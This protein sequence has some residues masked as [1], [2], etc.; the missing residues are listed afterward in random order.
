MRQVDTSL[1]EGQLFDR[2]F[3]ARAEHGE[4]RLL[5]DMRRALLRAKY[6]VIGTMLLGGAVAFA[7]AQTLEKRFTSYA[8]VMIDTRM[9]SEFGAG[10][11][12]VLPTTLTS[13]ESEL[14]V[15]RSLDLVEQ[16]VD[17]LDLDRD[18]EFGAVPPEDPQTEDEGLGALA[19]DIARALREAPSRLGLTGGSDQLPVPA[20]EA[21]VI[22][23]QRALEAVAER[24]TVEQVSDVS[25]VY[26]ISFTSADRMKAATIAN[27][28][29][30]QYLAL[31]I[32]AKMEQLDRS[33]EW[34]TD[35]ASALNDRLVGLTRDL[36]AHALRAPFPDS[37]SFQEAR[38]LRTQV[39]R[40][41]EAARTQGNQNAIAEF[42][43]AI[44]NIEG[45]LERQAAHQAEASRLESEVTV[46][47]AVYSNIVEQLGELQERGDLLGSDARIISH[48]RPAIRPSDPNV[49]ILAAAGAVLATLLVVLGVMAREMFQR[50]LRSV[51]DFEDTTHLPVIGFMPRSKSS[52]APLKTLLVGR[53]P[54]DRLVKSARKLT[55]SLSATGTP[56]QVIAGASSLPG[57][58]KTSTL[59]MLAHA[60]AEAGES[61]LL[62][63]FDFWRSPYRRA[64]SNP[65]RLLEALLDEPDL[66]DEEIVQV[67]ATCLHVLPALALGDVAA[68]LPLSPKLATFLARLR[69]RYQHILIDLPPVLPVVDF[70]T[71]A[72]SADATLLMIRWNSTPRSAVRSALGVLHD[73]GATPVGVIATLVSGEKAHTYADDAFSYANRRYLSGY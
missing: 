33:V 4:L 11:T 61:T 6:L 50:R 49:K 7:Y 39:A 19:R 69:Q 30:E 45:Q 41:L 35:R 2:R 15:L 9:P 24:R 65:R 55:A 43:A 23:Q 58:G 31:Q 27:S 25:A 44:S 10:A 62:L 8:R 17:V 63:D 66:V 26:E 71:V 46:A 48:A 29:A 38:E 60:Y 52:M 37:A 21:A 67:G 70:T 32:A 64:V 47:E 1:L 72:A 54:D 73:V 36:E 56:H 40:R 16:V 22:E 13:L 68:Q 3:A 51:S 34:L 28:F 59:L 53:R 57:E 14:E 18:P 5:D 42:E 12:G 20:P